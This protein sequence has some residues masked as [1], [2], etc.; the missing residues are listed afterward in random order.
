MTTF[1]Q[2]LDWGFESGHFE[3]IRLNF[4]DYDDTPYMTEDVDLVE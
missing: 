3:S 2:V 4:E 1:E